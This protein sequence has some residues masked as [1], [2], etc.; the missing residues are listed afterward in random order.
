MGAAQKWFI[1]VAI[2][3]GGWLLYLPAPVLTPFLVGALLAYLG[4]P[5]ADRMENTG[6]SRTP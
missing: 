1:L 6:L 3:A 5:V 2:L 4:D